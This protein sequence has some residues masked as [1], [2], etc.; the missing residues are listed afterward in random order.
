MSFFQNRFMMVKTAIQELDL[1]GCLASQLPFFGFQH[2]MDELPDLYGIISSRFALRRLGTDEGNGMLKWGMWIH[3]VS[4]FGMSDDYQPLIPAWTIPDNWSIKKEYCMSLFRKELP[5]VMAELL[6]TEEKE[7]TPEWLKQ[8][9]E[10]NGLQAV[11]IPASLLGA[12]GQVRQLRIEG[13]IEGSDLVKMLHAMGSEGIELPKILN[14]SCKADDGLDFLTSLGTLAGNHLRTLQLSL[15]ALTFDEALNRSLWTPFTHLRHLDIAVVI[16]TSSPDPLRYLPFNE[17]NRPLYLSTLKLTLKRGND[18]DFDN[19]APYL[20]EMLP[21]ANDLARA[22]YAI[23]GSTCAYTLLLLPLL[24]LHLDKKDISLYLQQA[25]KKK[26]QEAAN[27]VHAY[28]CFTMYEKMVQRELRRLESSQTS[29]TGWAKIDKAN[30]AQGVDDTIS[31]PVEIGCTEGEAK[32]EKG[33]EVEA[34]G[35]IGPGCHDIGTEQAYDTSDGKVSAG[36]GEAGIANVPAGSPETTMER[37]KETDSGDRSSMQTDNGGIVQANPEE[38]KSRPDVDCSNSASQ[39]G[40]VGDCTGGNANGTIHS[41][42]TFRFRSQLVR[43]T[44]L[45]LLDGLTWVVVLPGGG[46]DD[47]EQ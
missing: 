32:S 47:V 2:L 34:L 35:M 3:H 46:V 25:K 14:I 28:H 12:D 42:Y 20:E 5:A 38:E 6:S 31:S 17:S 21:T 45:Q 40:Q 23:G 27:S 11:H 8:I 33:Y 1:Y 19:Y 41:E 36:R 22:M 43:L 37:T 24:R 18:M 16:S 4:P 9:M 39:A 10:G 7:R 13:I 30:V 44:G 29:E 26:K 15:P